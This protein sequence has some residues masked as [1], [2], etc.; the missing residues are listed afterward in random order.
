MIGRATGGEMATPVPRHRAAWFTLLILVVAVVLAVAIPLRILRPFSS[1]TPSSIALAYQVHHSAPLGSALAAVAVV[2]LA[3]RLWPQRGGRRVALVGLIVVALLGAVVTRIDP[4]ER[5]FAPLLSPG[6]ASVGA[7][8]WV[9]PEDTVLALVETGPTG[10][11]A[12][13]IRQIGYHH[14]VMVDVGSK[15]LVATY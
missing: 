7:V 1:Q 10:G 11:H 6:F 12:F 3:I 14:V 2:L 13:P 15:H 8:D 9:A 4:F 5:M